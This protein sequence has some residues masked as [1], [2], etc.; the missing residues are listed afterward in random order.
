KF[1]DAANAIYDF[2][3][4]TFCD[5]YLELTKPLLDSEHAAEIKSTAAWVFD[6]ILLMLNPFMP[7]IS[8]ELFAGITP[9][10]ERLLASKWPEYM[11]LM[12][13]DAEREIGLLQSVINEI[14]SVRNDMNV[15]VTAKLHLQIR[16][17]SA[18]DKAVLSAHDVLVKRMARL[19]SITLSDDAAPKG[20]IQSVVGNLTLVL[21]VADIIDITKEKARLQKEI[22]K[23]TAE[24]KRVEAKLGN[25]QFVANAPEEIIAE[26]NAR[27]AEASAAIAKLSAAL[28]AIGEAA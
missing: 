4:G 18:S 7:F 23:Q 12:N 11:G 22:E 3:W 25:E 15:P 28:K 10:S 20:A 26:Q 6:Q 2:V 24:L 8:E 16:G 9:R 27:K 14:R 19:E 21:P 13:N 1:N 5:W 17:C